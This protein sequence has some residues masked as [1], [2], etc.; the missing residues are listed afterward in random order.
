MTN[1][2]PIIKSLKGLS[3]GKEFKDVQYINI[4]QQISLRTLTGLAAERWSSSNM[5]IFSST[6]KDEVGIKK[7]PINLHST[8][9]KMQSF[10][11]H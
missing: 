6:W 7:G 10:Q 8:P 5:G 3:L 4:R 9:T 11:A 2:K 1:E